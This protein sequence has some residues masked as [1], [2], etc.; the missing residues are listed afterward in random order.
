MSDIRQIE[1]PLKDQPLRADVRLLGYSEE[2]VRLWR[3]YL[4]YCEAGMEECYTGTSQLL[5][6]KPLARLSGTH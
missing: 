2:F 1:I 5:L 6:Q 4:S 3:F